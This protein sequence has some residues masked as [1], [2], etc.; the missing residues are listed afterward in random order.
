[1]VKLPATRVHEVSH[2]DAIMHACMHDQSGSCLQ[3]GAMWL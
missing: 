1:M 3:P 2:V